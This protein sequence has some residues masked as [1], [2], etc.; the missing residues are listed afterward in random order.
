MYEYWYTRSLHKLLSS[1]YDDD[2]KRSMLEKLASYNQTPGMIQLAADVT[3]LVSD[4]VFM[5]HWNITSTASFLD[6]W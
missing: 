5:V 6:I 3:M 1:Q 2:E 4:Q